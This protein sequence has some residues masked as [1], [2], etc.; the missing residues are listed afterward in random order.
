MAAVRALCLRD[1]AHAVLADLPVVRPPQGLRRVMQAFP[2][3][4]KL[5]TARAVEWAELCG[6]AAHS[7]LGGD[8]RGEVCG[9]A[10]L[11]AGVCQAQAAVAHGEG[12]LFRWWAV[13]AGLRHDGKGAVYRFALGAHHRW[14]NV[15]P[16][17]A[18][19]QVCNA[20]LEAAMK[21]KPAVL[22][23]HGEGQEL[24]H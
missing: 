10:F 12:E 3:Q 6:P 23:P 19:G 13:R 20:L 5:C 16:R 9:V 8:N 17:A 18:P 14:P 2:L 1:G 22:V 11:W 15:L 24:V 7:E 4:A 21:D